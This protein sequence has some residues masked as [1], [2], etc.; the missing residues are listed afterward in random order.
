M[1][2]K[3]LLQVAQSKKMYDRGRRPVTDEEIDL[4]L[5]WVSGKV[6]TAQVIEAYRRAD[7]VAKTGNVLYRIAVAVRV[8]H[9]KG[10]IKIS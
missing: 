4:A 2:E 6:V 10:R 1:K 7:G 3:T 8:A 9:Q 5:A